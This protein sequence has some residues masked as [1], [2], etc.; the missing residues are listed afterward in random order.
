MLEPRLNFNCPYEF[1]KAMQACVLEQGQG[2]L[3][4]KECGA[5]SRTSRRGALGGW[6]QATTA[7]APLCI[8]LARLQR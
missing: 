6:H 1:G 8:V 7:R 2:N 4:C 5:G 3:F